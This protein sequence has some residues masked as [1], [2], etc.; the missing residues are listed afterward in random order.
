VIENIDK[1]K[2]TTVDAI[3]TDTIKEEE[4]KEKD[5]DTI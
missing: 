4:E 2:H 5:Q 1:I 3:T